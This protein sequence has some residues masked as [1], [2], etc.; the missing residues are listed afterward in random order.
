M[1]CICFIIVVY[2]CFC[3]CI[4]VIWYWCIISDDVIVDDCIIGSGIYVDL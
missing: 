3:E 1:A 2:G 4:G